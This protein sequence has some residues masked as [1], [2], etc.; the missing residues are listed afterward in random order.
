PFNERLDRQ[1]VLETGQR[2]DD[3]ISH[4]GAWVRFEPDQRG[5]RRRIMNVPK[6]DADG[7]EDILVGFN[8]QQ[9][10]QYFHRLS[11]E[12][13]VRD[14]QLPENV[15]PQRSLL[16]TL[17]GAETTSRLEHVFRCAKVECFNG[18]PCNV[19]IGFRERYGDKLV[20]GSRIVPRFAGS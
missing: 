15:C 20:G 2:N 6:R 4:S 12:G 11:G 7:I 16:W 18:L 5:D 1:L 13:S 14:S 9:F 17:A 8:L 10:E 3:G 19:L